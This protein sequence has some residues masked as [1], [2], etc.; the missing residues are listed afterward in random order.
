MKSLTTS[1]FAHFLKV[2]IAPII[3]ILATL[4]A[5][6]IAS[7]TSQ[8]HGPS[9]EVI[10]EQA[11][12][13][14]E[15]ARLR[16]HNIAGGEIA[17]SR[18]NG[19][20]W[21][22]IGR[23]AQ[24]TMKVNPRGYNASKY[25]PLG[26][27]AATAVNA[28]HIKAGFNEKENRGIIFSLSPDS[29]TETGKTSLQSEVSPGSSAFTDIPGGTGIFGGPF[30]PFVGNPLFLDNDKNSDLKPLPENYV[31]KLGDVWTILIKRPI[32][33]PREVIF[34]NRFGGLITIQYR[35][36]EPRVI[37][38]V[39]RP[40]QGIGRFVGSYFSEVGRLRA[41]H[42]GVID[43]STSPYG[44]VGSFQIVPANHAMSPETHYIRELTQWMVV[45][46]VSALDP[47]WEG[48]SPLYSSFL[49]PRYDRNDVW[50]Q[51]WIEGLAGRFYFD[52]KTLGKNRVVS[53]WHPMPS[54]SVDA[55][56]SLPSWAGTALAN[57]THLRIVFPFA[58]NE[59]APV[60]GIATTTPALPAVAET[61][62]AA[63]PTEAEMQP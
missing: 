15:I 26:S 2:Q 47:S 4:L 58:W 62:A 13:T 37:G 9:P 43:V 11:P 27:V 12:P 31:P 16:I 22:F 40:V 35:G 56:A 50:D 36:E 6:S 8:G 7:A 53:D 25:T 30:T 24:P 23:V 54:L 57:V 60:T 55:K 21:Q 63:P 18:D 45:G 5:P 61:T 48:V 1:S 28:I 44:K 14:I 10:P 59:L 33:Y 19:Q 20:T 38:Q 46:P 39:L 42:N 41:N 52:V 34:E 3:L 17:G 32:R 49:R 51:D 29:N